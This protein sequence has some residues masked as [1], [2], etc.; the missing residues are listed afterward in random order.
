MGGLVVNLAGIFAFQ[1]AHS[2]GHSHGSS[3]GSSHGNSHGTAG[4][5]TH[6]HDHDHGHSHGN[7]HGHESCSGDGHSSRK[8]SANMQGKYLSFRFQVKLYYA[9]VAQRSDMNG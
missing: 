9:I 8:T 6:G 3:H 2:H 7:A 5:T 1:H 4:G